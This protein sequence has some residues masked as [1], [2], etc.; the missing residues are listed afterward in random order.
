MALNSNY[1]GFASPP[2]ASLDSTTGH[3]FNH[4]IQ[5]GYGALT[6]TNRPDD[7][8]VEGGATWMEDEVFDNANDNYHYL[9]PDFKQDMGNYTSSPYPYWI[10]FR[11]MTER[12]GTGS[13]GEGEQVMQDFWE[14]VS[15]QTTLDLNAMNKALQNRGTNLADAYHAYAIA[16]KFS[17]SCGGLYVLP[18]CFEEGAA[19][20]SSEGLPPLAGQGGTISSIGGSFGGSI[21][22][23]YALNWVVLPAGSSPY[24]ITMNNTSAG[25]QM[26]TTI[27]CDTGT[28]LELT[29]M[30]TVVSSG[31]STNLDSFDPSG[32]SQVVAVIT[33]QQQTASDPSSSTLRSYTVQT[34]G[35]PPPMADLTVTKAGAGSGTVASLPAGISCGSDCSHSYNEGTDVTLT[36]SP[37]A[38]ST[39]AGWSGA[40]SGTSDCNLDMDSDKSVTAT[41]D[42]GSPPSAPSLGSLPNFRARTTIPLDWSESSDPQTGIDHY[43]L[44]QQVA[45]PNQP[46]GPWEDGGTV[47]ATSHDATGD[48]GHTYCFRASATN[49]AGLTSGWSET[50]C[51][52]LPR[53]DRDLTA[54][55][56]WE[57]KTG[58]NYY[59]GTFLLSTK[60]GQTLTEDVTAKR[61]SLVATRCPGCGTVKV[62]LDDELLKQIS[63]ANETLKKRRVLPIAN[64]AEERAGTVTIKIISRAKPVQID[65]LGASPL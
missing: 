26:R 5:F 48:P 65:G 37:D 64:F 54:S 45:P 2:Q 63:L 4:S 16:V 56:S 11:G 38:G 35:T 27:A 24:G 22:S 51:T 31:A 52:S 60:R 42:D 21:A 23:N 8:F 3:E 43:S 36:A 41:F 9:W 46:F 1:T 17:K 34:G 10:T 59:L 25:G 15:K 33:N 49:G 47:S 19:Y 12:Y 57:L 53:D 14:E 40:C 18:Y 32:C 39:F 30:P 28:S 58:A 7:V 55:D 6:G 61:L 20:V 44:E 13:G 29:P 50:R 62:F